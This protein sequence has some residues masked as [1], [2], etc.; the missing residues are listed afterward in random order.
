MFRYRTKGYN[1]NIT[2]EWGVEM[3]ICLKKL[4]AASVAA[5]V[6]LSAFAACAAPAKSAGGPPSSAAASAESNFNA[7]GFPIVKEPVAKTFMIQK[8]PHIVDPAQMITF[9]KYEEKTNVKVKWEVVSNDGFQERVNL[10][11][12]SDSMPDAI[13][14]GV[15]DITKASAD[16]SIVDVSGLIDKYSVGLK[17]LFQ[18]YPAVKT[19][20]TAPDGKIYAIPN[21]NT[22]KPNLTSHRNLWINKKW[23]DKLNLETPKTL[24]EYVEA[25]KAFRDR[26]PNGNGKAD[27]IPYVVEPGGKNARS[28]VFQ[29]IWGIAGNLGYST[30]KGGNHVTVIDGKVQMI[31]TMDKY[32]QVLE[33]MNMMYKEKLLDN[34]CYTQTSDLGLSKFN[35]DVSGSFALSSDDLWSAYD[36]DYVALAPP[37][38]SYGDKPVIALG[39]SHGGFSMVITKADKTPEITMRWVDYFYTKEGSNFIGGLSPEFEGKTCKKLPDGSYGYSDEILNSDKGLSMAVGSMCPLPGGGFPYW[40]NE[41]NSLFVYSDKVKESVPVY[42]PYYQKDTAY[43]YPVFSLEDKE[44]VDDIRRDLDVY[45]DECEAKFITGETSFDKWDEY[46]ATCKKM[47]IDELQKYF[48]AAYDKMKG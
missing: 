43:S 7:A 15:P 10:V 45:L 39:P 44:K 26:D 48:Q 30:S 35:S 5:A 25:L 21:V 31:P 46:V 28:D 17:A 8:P 19:A 33:F 40:R 38:N 24:D 27:E 11:M 2:K 16:G 22:L 6:G 47:G 13:L 1:Q 36:R 41:T 29:G 4:A 12:A 20:S 18:E 9:Q 34:A 14:K 37:T 23:L 3:E 32:K 42:E